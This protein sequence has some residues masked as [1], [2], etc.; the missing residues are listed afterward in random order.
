MTMAG[1][2]RL[3]NV[4]VNQ[5]PPISWARTLTAITFFIVFNFGC[6]MVNGSQ[7]LV[8]LPLR[9]LP[10]QSAHAYYDTGLRMSKGAFGTLLVLMCHWFSPARLIVTFEGDGPGAFSQEELLDLVVRDKKGAVT[11]LNLPQK[12][13]LI[14]NHQVYA[15]WWYAWCLTYFMGTHRDVLIVLKKSLKWLPI[16]GWGMQFFNFIFLARSWASDRV[17][18]VKQLDRLGRQA[19]K[20]DTPLTF[21]LYPEGTLV[22]TDTRP[23]SK[24]FA[25]KM[26]I[27]DMSHLLLPRSTG[28]HYSLRALAPRISSLQLLDVTVA[29]PGIPPMGYG[30][31]Y[32]TLRSIFFNG[33]AP[34][35]IHMHIRKFDV[36]SEV[37]IGNVLKK[38]STDSLVASAE[39]AEVGKD[40]QQIFDLWVRELWTQKDQFMERFLNTGTFSPDLETSP[41]VVIPLRPRKR[42]EVLDA[43]CFFVPATAGYVWARIR[44][45]I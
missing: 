37:P 21:I 15:D 24:K 33:V 43:F 13:V 20:Q 29:Y 2:N 5:R 36:A 25:D 27:P 6:L 9:L 1:P 8:L 7:F 18:L 4:P 32:Y 31:S 39:V 34:P 30:Q 16:V 19:E 45:C 12:S 35:A 3:Y 40:E 42:R 23:I 11:A 17:Y 14:A 10:F 44:R 26:G 28:L 38:K 41:E 22:S